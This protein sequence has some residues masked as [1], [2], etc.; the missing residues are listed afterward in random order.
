MEGS[1]EEISR[2]EVQME[3]LFDEISGFEVQILKI[4]FFDENSK[5]LKWPYLQF[6]TIQNSKSRKIK[7]VIEF[8]HFYPRLG[9]PIVVIF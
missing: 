8:S 7:K 9:G 4:Q 2:I 1:S 5:I 3:G 6:P